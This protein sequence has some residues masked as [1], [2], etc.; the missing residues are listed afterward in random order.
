MYFKYSFKFRKLGKNHV[1]LKIVEN[2]PLTYKHLSG[3]IDYLTG[4]IEYLIISS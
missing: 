1:L 4:F 2:Y 3:F